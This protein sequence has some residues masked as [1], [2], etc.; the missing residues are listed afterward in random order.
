VVRHPPEPEPEPDRAH[1][2]FETTGVEETEP[3]EP[4]EDPGTLLIDFR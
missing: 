3:P 4:P 1:T 2:G